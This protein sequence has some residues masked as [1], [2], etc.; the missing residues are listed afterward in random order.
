MNRCRDQHRERRRDRRAAAAGMR[1]RVRPGH[2]LTV[3]DV[4]P[5]GALVE[6]DRA[7]RPGTRVEVHL[8]TDTQRWAASAR[9]VR[10]AVAAIDS[11]A[12]ITYRAALA[13]IE[14]CEWLREAPT[15]SG[16]PVRAP[17]TGGAAVPSAADG[18]A[19]PRLRGEAWGA[20]AGISK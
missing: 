6:V 2:R 17:L 15:P 18:D 12:G 5:G 10:C 20:P 9:V 8:E 3:I 11:E 14:T 1:A 19:L 16:Y 7:L 4:G 13:F